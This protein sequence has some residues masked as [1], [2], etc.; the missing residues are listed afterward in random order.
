MK[1]FSAIAHKPRQYM[2]IR[3]WHFYP[4]TL[5]CFQSYL[6]DRNQI[7]VTDSIQSLP[8]TLRSGVPTSQGLLLV[9]LS[10]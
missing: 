5:A 6:T 3:S 1:N 8:F 2:P 7:F 10:S 9:Q 4:P